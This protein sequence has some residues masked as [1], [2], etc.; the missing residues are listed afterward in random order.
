VGSEAAIATGADFPDALSIAAIAAKKGMPI[1]LS[2]TNSLP[3]EI[4]AYISQYKITKTYIIGGSDVVSDGVMSQLP[5]PERI[6]GHDRYDTNA[7]ILNRF[8]G[9]LDFSTVYLAT[10]EDF[11][12]ALSGSAL[13]AKTGSPVVLTYRVPELSTSN[14]IEARCSSIKQLRIFG[15]D[16]VVPNPAVSLLIPAVNTVGNTSANI[17]YAGHATKQ[18]NWIYYFNPYEDGYGLYK[19]RTD[20]SAKQKLS[21]RPVAY[22]NVVGEWIYFVDLNDLSTVCKV[23]VDGT[24]ETVISSEKTKFLNVVGD[25]M[26]YLNGSDNWTLYKMKTDCT[27]KTKLSSVSINNFAVYGDWIYYTTSDYAFHKVKTDGTGTIDLSNFNALYFNVVDNWVYYID[28]SNGYICKVSTD[29]TGKTIINREA[30][31]YLNIDNGWIYYINDND[32]YTLYK[33]RVDGTGRAKLN[34]VSTMIENIAGDW[35][36]YY[37]LDSSGDLSEY[38]RMKTNGTGREVIQ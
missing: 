20:N 38:C 4:K 18:G 14:S 25:W 2:E 7:A 34:N 30:S 8:A 24:G 26:Y 1:L 21:N 37:E 9:D 32:N 6:Y 16:D 12:D 19:I 13:A 22:I 36:Y 28:L 10:G 17:S 11:P 35:I 31:E 5:G 33:I 29:G 3:A 15:G 27:Q 23:R